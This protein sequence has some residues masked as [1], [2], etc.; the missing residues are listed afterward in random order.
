MIFARNATAIKPQKF[1]GKKRQELVGCHLRNA[2]T[3]AKEPGQPLVLFCEKG[4]YDG[5][6][7]ELVK[8]AAAEKLRKLRLPNSFA[9]IFAAPIRDGKSSSNVYVDI[10]GRVAKFFV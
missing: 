8:L 2:L 1:K 7:R 3:D 4:D 5:R 10:E 6:R 9:V